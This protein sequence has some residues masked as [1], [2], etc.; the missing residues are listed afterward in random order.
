MLQS[1]GKLKSQKLFSGARRELQWRDKQ[2]QRFALR[3]IKAPQQGD[4]LCCEVA[5]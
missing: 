3:A 4:Q 5:S 1:I 2:K